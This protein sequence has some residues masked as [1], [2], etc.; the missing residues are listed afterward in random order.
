MINGGREDSSGVMVLEG[1]GVSID[2][3]E[4]LCCEVLRS[5]ECC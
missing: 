1:V 2:E 4:D 5:W 3:W